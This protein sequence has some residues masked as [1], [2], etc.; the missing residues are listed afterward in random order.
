MASAAGLANRE[1]N[2]QDKLNAI[3][4]LITR[5]NEELGITK[6]EPQDPLKMHPMGPVNI[7]DARFRVREALQQVRGVLTRYTHQLNTERDVA[8]NKYLKMLQDRNNSE[9]A[10]KSLERS[11]EQCQQL[12]NKYI[13]DSI[14][15]AVETQKEDNKAISR[16]SEKE[17]SQQRLNQMIHRIKEVGEQAGLQFFSEKLDGTMSEVPNAHH[18]ISLSSVALLFDVYLNELGNVENVSLTLEDG[19]QKPE[20]NYELCQSIK[21]G[22]NDFVDKI[23]KLTNQDKLFQELQA[24]D[25]KKVKSVMEADL[26]L[27]HD[28]EK[29]HYKQY[30][31]LQN[32]YG[33]MRNSCEGLVIY[34]YLPKTTMSQWEDTENSLKLH[35]MLYENSVKEIRT[36][37]YSLLLGVEKSGMNEKTLAKETQLITENDRITLKDPSIDDQDSSKIPARFVLFGDLLLC[38]TAV[39]SLVDLLTERDHTWSD[40]NDNMDTQPIEYELVAT[41]ASSMEKQKVVDGVEHHY[42]FCGSS[43]NTSTIRINRIPF[44][45]IHQVLPILQILRQQLMFSELFS[46][47]F[48]E[49]GREEPT[50]AMDQGSNWRQQKQM[51][52]ISTE[53]PGTISATLLHPKTLSLICL[54]VHILPGGLIQIRLL[55]LTE[56][57]AMQWASELSALLAGC[58]SIP[59]VVNQLMSKLSD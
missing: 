43:V 4:T 29:K 14:S 27:L 1:D 47:C 51:I 39:Q 7:D 59:H 16:F 38:A 33:M 32:K 3:K 13:Q 5:T 54:S 22:F 41:K 53:S 58:R 18:Q 10:A 31:L 23:T 2:V 34:F 45:S 19:T 8:L 35:E 50:Q 17:Q 20:Y 15:Q 57:V 12:G 21:R 40:M 28:D 30:E 6:G 25:L 37:V 52:E 46:S 36:Q 55:G 42:V 11:L 44:H 9:S 26:L 49:E 56:E 24:Y 48:E